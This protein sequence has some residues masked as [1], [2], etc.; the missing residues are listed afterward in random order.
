MLCT[1]GG[2]V[3]GELGGVGSAFEAVEAGGVDPLAGRTCH[4]QRPTAFSHSVQTC[5]VPP[6]LPTFALRVRQAGPMSGYLLNT[7]AL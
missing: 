4:N 6:H 7:T 3:G 1:K 2:K 5:G